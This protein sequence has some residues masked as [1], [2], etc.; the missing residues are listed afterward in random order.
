[1]KTHYVY[2]ITNRDTGEYYY[3]KRSCEGSWQD[4]NYMGSGTLLKNKMQ[5]HPDQQWHKEVLMLLDTEEEAFKYETISVGDRWNT[6]SLCL[7]LKPGGEGSTSDGH[8]A[9]WREHRDNIVDGLRRGW[10]DPEVKKARIQSRQDKVDAQLVAMHKGSFS[11]EVA[12]SESL[13][14][15]MNGWDYT[16][17]MTIKHEGRG[18]WIQPTLWVLH[19]MLRADT[20]WT[21]G[22]GIGLRKV[23]V[24]EAVEGIP[25]LE[26][27]T[28]SERISAGTK[29]GWAKKKLLT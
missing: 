17:R 16:N 14:W 8:K 2:K 28:N 21:I 29:Y 1:V 9:I 27:M 23:K 12:R 20:G 24:T 25:H 7:N 5:A 10:S 15:C 6:D 18:I 22:K 11:G 19:E 4:D 3:G 13:E 26:A